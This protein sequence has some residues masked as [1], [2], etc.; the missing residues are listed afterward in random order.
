MQAFAVE[1]DASADELLVELA[2]LAEDLRSGQHA[3]FAV[4]LGLDQDHESHVGS[5]RDAWLKAAL[6]PLRPGWFV[7][8]TRRRAGLRRIDRGAELFLQKN[9]AS[10]RLFFAKRGQL[11]SSSLYFMSR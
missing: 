10:A 1:H 8:S 3:R 9:R 6:R 2:P 5:P 11:L 4:S 7:A